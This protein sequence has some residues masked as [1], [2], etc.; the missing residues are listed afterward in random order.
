LLEI[1]FY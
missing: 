1:Y